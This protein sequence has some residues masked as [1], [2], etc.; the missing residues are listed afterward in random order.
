MS[1]VGHHIHTTTELPL[2]DR[3]RVDGL[4]V[5]SG[6]RTVIDLARHCG[7]EALA[8][9][10]DSGL[11]DG[12]FNESLLHRRIAAL[13][14]K[15]RHG[16]PSLLAV[17]EGAEIARGGHSWLEREFLRLVA[18]AGLPRP[19]TQQTLARTGS[20]LVRVDPRFA[21]TNVVVEL[22]GYRFH[23]TKVELQHDAERCNAL[24]LRGLLPFQFTYDHVVSHS[25]WLIATLTEALRRSVSA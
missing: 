10:I 16:I 18:R 23:R 8:A 14:T 17:I 22:L 13:R 25:V 1:R 3:A 7:P 21:G 11:R 20:R 12:K 19:E 2:I 9:A 15:G 6:A 5:T 4:T 24:I